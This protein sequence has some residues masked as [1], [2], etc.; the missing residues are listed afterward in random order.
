M[1]DAMNAQLS[2]VDAIT[3]LSAQQLSVAI[4]AR[5]VSCREV[6]Q[7][8]LSRVAALNPLVNAIVSLRDGD[9]LLEE[10][11]RHDALLDQGRSKGWMHGMPL[12][13]K[14]LANAKG[15]PTTL[16]S[17]LMQGFVAPEDGLLASRMRAAG[18]IFIG[19]TNV[20]EFGLGSHTF[21]EVFGPTRNPYDLSKTCGGSSGGA[22]AA[23]ATHLL[24]V[25]DGSDFMGSLR[26]PAGWCNIVGYRP[27]QGLVPMWPA[28]DVFISQLGTEGPMGRTV[29]DV[30]RLLEV[31][32]GYDVNAPL[33]GAEYAH[34]QTGFNDF[35]L[36]DLRLGWLGD[37]NGHLAMEPGVLAT[38]ESAL[39]RMQAAGATLEPTP[40]GNDAG[41]PGRL[42]DAWLVWRRLLVAGRLM[43][44]LAQPDN[45]ARIKPEALWEA[46]QASM[47]RGDEFMRASQQRSACYQQ[48]CRL[49]ERFDVLALPSAQV[50]PFDVTMRWPQSIQT[51][52]GG[53]GMD[54]YHR[55]ME[56]T[57]YA[58]FA[59]LPAVCMPAGFNAAGLPM[60]IQLIGKPRGDAELLRVARA[61]EVLIPD[62]MQRRPPMP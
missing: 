50:W 38:C 41:L 59:G 60:G 17:P 31:Q 35:S 56:V 11:D 32:S 24:P 8:Y 21:N 29:E 12:A 26:N 2:A 25:A 57:I 52:N 58:T 53:R 10:A 47:L 13:L 5:T 20:P 33:S 16:G 55:W 27:S 36:K 6:M 1:V 14:D 34:D 30:S 62:L 4:H 42:W 54:T 23:L 15:L 28:S 43:P 44:F 48:I 19:K 49:F 37:L 51:E 7:A 45:R 61:Y 9:Q 39:G 40:L 22:A 3:G 18:A 46:D